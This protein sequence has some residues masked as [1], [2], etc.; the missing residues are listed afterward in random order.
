MFENLAQ[1]LKKCNVF[2][3][4]WRKKMGVWKEK[5]LSLKKLIK[6]DKQNCE[7]SKLGIF[8]LAQNYQNFI[9]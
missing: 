3:A 4:D 9:K 8:E 6:R 7:C 1:N 2:L 5:V